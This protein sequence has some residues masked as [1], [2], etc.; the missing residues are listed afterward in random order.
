MATKTVTEKTRDEVMARGDG[1]CEMYRFGSGGGRCA[2]QGGRVALH[3]VELRSHGGGNEPENLAGLCTIHHRAVHCESDPDHEHPWLYRVTTGEHEYAYATKKGGDPAWFLWG[4]VRDRVEAESI[5]ELKQIEVAVAIDTK[6]GWRLADHAWA[7]AELGDA[8][9]LHGFDNVAQLAKANNKEPKTLKA[10]LLAESRLDA[11][12]NPKFHDPLKELPIRL[13][14]NAGKELTM[15]AESVIEEMLER[16]AA[17]ET[18]NEL[19]R[20]VKE[21][22]RTKAAEDT[23]RRRSTVRL[24][25]KAATL[26]VPVTYDPTDDPI[27]KAQASIEARDYVHAIE[28]GKCEVE[29]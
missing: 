24:V 19:I 10:Y 14:V 16:A 12:I 2:R 18:L 4:N 22:A 29:K 15:V 1:Q 25:V 8:W 28:W 5:E 21:S 13:M 11:F 6:A 7:L 23:D 3:H 17:G 27:E 9:Q 20:F 26:I